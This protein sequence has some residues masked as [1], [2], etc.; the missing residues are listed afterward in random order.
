MAGMDDGEWPSTPIQELF[1]SRCVLAQLGFTHGDE[2]EVAVPYVEK[3]CYDP[4]ISATIS[5]SQE[6]RLVAFQ[7]CQR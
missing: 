5:P 4:F 6:A 7:D 3:Y 2:T 1:V